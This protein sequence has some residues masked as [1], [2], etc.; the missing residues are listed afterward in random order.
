MAEIRT[1]I[2]E[3]AGLT[4][5]L[6][7]G[8]RGQEQATRAMSGAIGQAAGG[9]GDVASALSDLS[10]SV[11]QAD[12]EA[13]RVQ[14]VADR[15]GAVV[16]G[17]SAAVEEFAE[18]VE[19][20]ASERRSATRSPCDIPVSVHDG[21]TALQGRIRDICEF[22]A[23]IET[24]DREALGRLKEH[25]GDVVLVFPD[26]AELRAAVAWVSAK[27]IGLWSEDAVFARFV[28][29]AGAAAEAA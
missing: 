16:A 9:V 23:R 11:A 12:D 29:Q 19:K 4:H 27:A 22:G 17:L 13:G 18:G 20:D 2:E 14:A 7:E 8:V 1:V 6:A 25:D 24:R 15:L 28:R 5:S 21:A 10:G 3:V 26:G